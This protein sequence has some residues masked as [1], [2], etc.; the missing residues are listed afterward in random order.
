[1]RY[2][3]NET[4]YRQRYR[5]LRRLGEGGSSVVYMAVDE[6]EKSPVTI[7]LFKE[8]AHG[9]KSAKEMVE[10]ETKI[11]SQLYHE[12]I[13]EL[14]AVYDDAAVISYI[15]GNSLEKALAVKGRFAEKEAVRMML[16]VLGILKYLHEQSEPVIYRDLKPANLMLRPDT[17]VSLIDFGAARVMEKECIA[18]TLNLGTNGFA[19]PEQY[20]NLGQTDPRTDIYCF[21]RT[22]LLLVG[23]KCSPELM[24]VIEKCTMPDRDDRFTNCREVEKALKKYPLRA[25]A[26]RTGR[27]FKLAA[28]SAIL[29]GVISFAVIHYDSVR[30]YAADDASKRMPAVQQRLN[31]AGVRFKEILRERFGVVI[32][33]GVGAYGAGENEKGIKDKKVSEALR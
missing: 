21:G 14:K 31:T 25:M 22:L 9:K 5:I 23:G 2:L 11:M 27:G 29:A 30:S 24:E 17:H 13:P 33:D 18:D 7:K 19:A 12:G 8:S 1:M 16:E 3:E 26:H 15:P 6:K 10:A 28:G 4:I 32:G 20:G